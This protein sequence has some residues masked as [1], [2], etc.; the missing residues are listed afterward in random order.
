MFKG[1]RTLGVDWPWTN[2]HS[3]ETLE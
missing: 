1:K 3:S 2:C